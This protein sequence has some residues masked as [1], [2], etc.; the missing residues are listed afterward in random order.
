MKQYAVI[1]A[2]PPWQYRV[3]ST[4]HRTRGAELHYPT[5]CLEE[6]KALPVE[7]LAARDC[8]LFLWA[9]MPNLRE[10]M[11]VIE[12][13]GFTYKTVAFVWVKQN[14]LADSLFWGMG[15]WTRSNAELC[16][17]AT[18]GHPKRRSTRVHQVLLSHVE[19]HSRKPR[20]VRERIEELMGRLPR[21]ELFAREKAPGWDAWG[22][23]IQ[24]DIS[25]ERREANGLCSGPAGPGEGEKQGAV[26]PDQAAAPV[27]RGS[28]GPGDPV[29]S[30][31]E[32]STGKHALGMPHDADRAAVF[33]AG[34]V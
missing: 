33:P 26:Q 2:D 29:L 8:V 20:E 30:A 28:R 23:E 31:D 25:L 11:E 15:Y 1:Y 16:L 10:A 13:W 27:L 18:R 21:I 17:L 6:I 12:A 14:K 34:H 7:S 3:Y 22:N 24:S 4:K 19:E 32:E 9:T 5:M